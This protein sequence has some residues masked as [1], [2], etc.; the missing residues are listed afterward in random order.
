[1]RL[2]ILLL[3]CFLYS[4]IWAQESTIKG[5]I[6]DSETGEPLI[7]ATVLYEAGKGSLTDFNGEFI[8]SVP[9]G[10]YTLQISYTGFEPIQK[11]ISVNKK[12]IFLEFKWALRL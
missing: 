12:N 9:Y 2:H 5:K 11:A 10:D 3:S 4:F 6:T 8:L 7:G 1:M